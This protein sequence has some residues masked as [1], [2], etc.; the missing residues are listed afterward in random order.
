MTIVCLSQDSCWWSVEGQRQLRVPSRGNEKERSEKKVFLFV[1]FLK[2][3]EEWTII[4]KSMS[5]EPPF[6]LCPKEMVEQVEQGSSR[7]NGRKI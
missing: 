6:Y 2:R 3:S 7:E 1:F 4:W 5:G